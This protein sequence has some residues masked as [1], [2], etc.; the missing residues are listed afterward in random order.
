M[1]K[2][3]CQQEV[4]EDVDGEQADAERRINRVFS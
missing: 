1:Q 4:F 3:E 2:Y